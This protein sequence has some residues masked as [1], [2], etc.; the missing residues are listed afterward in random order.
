MTVQEILEEVKK[1]MAMLGTE[2]G[3]EKKYRWLRY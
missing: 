2:S 1:I 3:E